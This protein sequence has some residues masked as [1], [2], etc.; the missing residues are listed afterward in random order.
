MG[1]GAVA[2]RTG[3]LGPAATQGLASLLLNFALPML[4]FRSFLRPFDPATLAAALRMLGYSFMLNILLVLLG[5]GL[6]RNGRPDRV[7]ALRFI[8]AFSN[9]G[10]LGLPLLGA[11]FPRDGVFYGAVFG[12]AC[13][14]CMF[15]LG[16]LLFRPGGEGRGTWR[17]LLNPAI[18]STFLGTL[19]F[20]ASLRLPGPAVAVLES[21][22]GLT[23]PVSMLIV[24]A[25]LAEGGWRN[26]RAGPG[27]FLVS[28]VRL[29]L[30]PLLT[31][32]ACRLVGAAPMATRVLVILEALP[33]AT[34]VAL[35]T[36]RYGGDRAFVSRCLFVS[37]ALSLLTLPFIVRV[38]ERALG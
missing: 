30:V 11:L 3:V 13:N 33:A 19:A 15:S 28:A 36:E 18:L 26:L 16:I 2:R 5:R 24:G 27:E 23:G 34:V 17:L 4:V 8:T 22:G 21:M 6:F 35:F 7:P 9:S 38:M 29:L 12:V 20:V 32:L 14:A 1:V 31:L 37:T 25:M 10:F